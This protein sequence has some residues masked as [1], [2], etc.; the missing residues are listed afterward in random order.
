MMLITYGIQEY[1]PRIRQGRT[2]DFHLILCTL[3]KIP[4]PANARGLYII[5]YA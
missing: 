3:F 1:S 5:R 4:I 2:R